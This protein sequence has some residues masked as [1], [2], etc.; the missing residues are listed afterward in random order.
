MGDA[1]MAKKKRFIFDENYIKRYA[2]KDKMRFLVIG[3]SALVLI[4]IIIIVILA[5]KGGK[6]KPKPNIVPVFEFKEEMTVEAGSVM[7]EV[8][9]YFTKL[10]NIS[11][12]DIKIEYPDDFEIGYNMDTCS[13]EDRE[14]INNLDNHEDISKFSCAVPI[15]KTPDNYGVTLTIQDKE[16]T[17]KLNVV[18]ST[19]PMVITKDIE[20]YEEDTYELSDF[21]QLC[22]DA[23]SECSISYYDK[24]VDSNGNSIDYSAFKNA[25]DYTIRLIAKDNYSNVTNPI[26]ARLT[27]K[28]AE[29]PLYTVT[30]DS[31][32]GSEVSKVFVQ[33][34]GSIVMPV[35]PTRSGYYFIGWYNGDT[36]YDFKSEVTSD[37][38]LIAKWETI[39]TQEEPKPPVGP[40]PG[41]PSVIQVRSIYLDF[42]TINLYI[43][44]SKTVKAVVNPSNAS[45]KTVTWSSSD[46]G[47]ATVNN[48]V[49]TG[50][51]AGTV[52]VTAT[53]GSKSASVTVVVREKSGGGTSTDTCPY[54][55]TSYNSSYIMSVNLS[56]NGCA[57]NP[58]GVHN[59][60]VSGRDYQ[61]MVQSLANLGYDTTTIKY[62]LDSKKIKNN[63]GTGV[64][65][66]QFTV[67]VSVKD[68]N[69]YTLLTSE[70]IIKPDGSRQMLRSGINGFK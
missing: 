27:I 67:T 42:K 29:S 26:E 64:V 32:G 18:D 50:V 17:V 58:N 35:A 51:K 69:S 30:F 22:Y 12:E 53:A 11:I 60:T 55:D 31:Q 43:G 5:S 34:G 41:V 19:A 40:N 1:I 48:G 39:P 45:D 7:P 63:A 15:L 24:D 65:G 62:S 37:M 23:T 44:D 47:V 20:I 66:Y 10:E 21:I 56:Q 4:I 25:G 70:Y 9:D 28:Q 46:A 33:E 54:G 49:I 61:A 3:V 14:K 2:N 16:Y 36:P 52:T 59:E 13:D 6:I 68:P 57:I 8:A 38:T